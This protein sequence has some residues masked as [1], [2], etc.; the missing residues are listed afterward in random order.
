MDYTKLNGY[1]VSIDHV[2]FIGDADKTPH[3]LF[4]WAKELEKDRYER[5]A[6]RLPQAI[7]ESY[8]D[9]VKAAKEIW[10]DWCKSTARK[11]DP[12][13]FDLHLNL[14]EINNGRVYAVDAGGVRLHTAY[15]KL[16]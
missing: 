1:V 5:W 6:T 3:S 14:M 4:V 12:N 9:A 8:D 10:A 15:G 13:E 11:P 16:S 7:V 2:K